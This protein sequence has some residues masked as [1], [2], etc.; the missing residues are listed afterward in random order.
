MRRLISRFWADT[1]GATAIEYAMIAAGL[2]I[3]IVGVVTALGNSLAGKYTSVS[4]AMK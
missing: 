2:S 4:E 1:R 3:V